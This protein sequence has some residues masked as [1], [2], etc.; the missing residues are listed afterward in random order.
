VLYLLVYVDD[1]ILTKNDQAVITTLLNSLNSQFSI[2]DLGN[3]HYFLSIKVNSVSGGLFLTQTT[4]LHSILERANMVGAKPCKTPIQPGLKL[5]KTNDTTLSDPFLYRTIVGALQYATIS[6]PNLAFSINEA[7]QFV[8]APTDV[9]WQ[10]V[11]RI[12]QYVKDTLHHGLL[13]RHS[14]QLCL[15][16]YCDADWAGDPDDRRSTTGYVVYLGLNIV[17]WPSKKH[18][19]VSRSS[20]EA[21]YRSL[22]MTTSELLWLQSLLTELGQLSTT[23]LVLWCDNL[24]AIFLAAISVFHARTKHIELDFHFVREKLAD[25]KLDVRFLCSADQ[26]EDIFTKSLAKT[27]FHTLTVKRTVLE[28]PLC[29]RGL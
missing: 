2:K 14:P 27:R 20:T 4:Y 10:L 9:H 19:T 16:A 7:S 12:L 28:K 21:E 18:A 1:I 3:L 15:N 25:K 22:A 5:S 26:I 8:S 17:S 13:L 29:L 11:K 6:R 23:T 24:G